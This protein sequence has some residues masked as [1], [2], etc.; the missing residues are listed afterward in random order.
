MASEVKSDLEFE[1]SDLDFI[2]S[3][4]YLII[5]FL[6]KS[7]SKEEEKASASH[8]EKQDIKF[9]SEVQKPRNQQLPG[10]WTN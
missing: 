4:V 3:N 1:L 2:C 8:P 10:G 6:K 5:L 9:E 7:I